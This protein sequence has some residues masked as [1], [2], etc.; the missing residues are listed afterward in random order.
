MAFVYHRVPGDMVGGV[1]YPL[2]QLA[3]IAPETYEF[4]KSK[5][6]GRETVMD[7]RIPHLGLLFND[8]VHCAPLHPYHLF[9]ARRSLG[10]P[11][12]RASARQRTSRFNGLFFEIPLERITA[13]PVAWYQWKTLWING[14]PNEDVPLAPPLEEFE[15]F[16][17]SRYRELTAVT[18]SH[19]SYLARMRERGQPPLLFVHIPHVL[20]AGPIEIRDLRV[21]PWDEPPLTTR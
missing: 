2:N 6:A 18:D 14:A 12:P 1:V 7:F 11:V 9:D 8:T 20:V 4:Q 19:L 21:I 3:A 17:P 15:P 16:D 5:Y 10:F 13:H